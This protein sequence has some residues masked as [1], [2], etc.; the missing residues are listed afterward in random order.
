MPYLVNIP[1]KPVPFGRE[2]RRSGSGEE[3]RCEKDRREE[4]LQL[5][6]L[7]EKRVNKKKKLPIFSITSHRQN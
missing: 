3:R 7:Y 5:H 1:R 4:K 2:R 6:I